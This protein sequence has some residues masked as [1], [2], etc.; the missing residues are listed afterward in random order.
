[1]LCMSYVVAVNLDTH[2]CTLYTISR[3]SNTP[4]ATYYSSRSRSQAW[5]RSRSQLSYLVVYKCIVSTLQNVDS[6]VLT[7]IYY[8][9]FSL[10]RGYA[11]SYTSAVLCMPFAFIHIHCIHINTQYDYDANK[12]AIPTFGAQYTTNSYQISGTV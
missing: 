6:S 3:S 1:M 10:L 11:T 2:S 7:F 8:S 5:S 9:T 12:W 4:M